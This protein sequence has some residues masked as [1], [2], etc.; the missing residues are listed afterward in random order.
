VP[1]VL[2]Y[3]L[4]IVGCAAVLIYLMLIFP[5]QWVKTVRMKRPLG[6]GKRIVQVS[7]MHVERLR[8]GPK[9][10]RKLIVAEQ[11]DYI[12]LT[13]DYTE[14]SKYIAR[15]S[16]YLEEFKKVGVPI[17]AI[18]GNHDYRLM[19]HFYEL[20]EA[21]EQFEI[22]LLR[23][24]SVQLDGF[25]LVGIDDEDAGLANP[26]LALQK[27]KPH[28]KVIILAHNPNVTLKIYHSYSYMMCGHFHG[29]QF[30]LPFIFHLK[31]KG[32]LPR[33]GIYEGAH[34]NRWGEFY[35]S[36]GIGQSELNARFL[37][38]SEFTVHDL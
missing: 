17:Y 15:V 38:R 13:G 20:A 12:F 27:V 36:R 7:D 2:L 30:R 16:R 32:P 33:Q 10:L 31:N 23:N 24:E 4:G 11:P 19:E 8:I 28:D 18:L 22:P 37:I 35:I 1:S 34:R 5:T 25:T 14:N 21:F 3:V 29:R 26:T 6:L 9:R